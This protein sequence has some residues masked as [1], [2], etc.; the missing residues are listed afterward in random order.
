[1]KKFI[2][3]L[4]T[5][6]ASVY[7]LMALTL[8][9]TSAFFAKQFYDYDKSIFIPIQKIID[10][11]AP[12]AFSQMFYGDFGD[13]AL[14]KPMDIAVINEFIYITDTNNQRVQ[15]FDLGGTP[16]YKFGKE[17][18]GKG[19][20]RFPYGIAG[21]SQGNVYV[22]DLYNGSISVFDGKGNFIKYFAEQNP[23]ENTIISPGGLRIY[24]DK[25]YVTEIQMSKVLVFDMEGKKLKEIGEPGVNPGQFRAPNAVTVDRE[26]NIYVVD[27]GNQRVQIFDQEGKLLRMINGS[28]DGTG[29]SVFVNPRGIGIDSRGI[30]Y[31]VSN[32]THM[33]HGF[34]QNDPTVNALFTFGGNGEAET[35]FSLPN[36]LYVDQNDRVYITDT[37]NQRI[38][39]YQ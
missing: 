3:S 12:P 21:D 30:I 10:D 2:I 36:G 29:N 25:V 38:A 7:L 20:F 24:N 34:D 19:E 32:L 16:I 31:V 4:L 18:E 11:K 5:K 8:I 37:M 28:P 13:G 17:G 6:K 15:V 27:T 14:N 39:V 33:V 22:A 23:K 1:M 26:G 35:Q 9:S